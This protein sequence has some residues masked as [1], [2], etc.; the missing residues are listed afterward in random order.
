M[1]PLAKGL[2]TTSLI[3]GPLLTISSNHWIM[4]WCGLEIS[5]LSVIPLIAQQHHPRAI[6]A[7]IKYFLTQA[8]A[9]TM[10]LFSGVM[11][12]WHLGQWDMTLL[13]NNTLCMLLT[14]ALAMKLGLA[15]FHLWLPEV[16]QGSTMMTALLLTTW[17]KLAPL[18][19]LVITSHHLNAPLLLSLGLA[20]TLIGGWGGLNQTQLR[21]IMAFSSIAHLGWMTAILTMSPKLTLL[22]FYL[23]CVMTITTFLMIEHLKTNKMSTIMLSWTKTPSLNT[24]MLLTLMSLAGLPPLTGFSPKW[25]ILQELTKQHMTILATLMA[26]ASLL[27]LFFYLRVSY[28]T[29]ITLPPNSHNY[30]QQWRH[31]TSY[32]KPYLAAMAMLSTTLLPILPALLYS[33]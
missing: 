3:M 28:Y 16:L 1:N 29:T 19:I 25:L 20:S 15:P 21:K 8:A 6:E 7:A 23:Y 26:M 14:V 4:A 12:A 22:T 33:T 27:S 10:L 32:T 17:Q 11:N 30:T 18:T 5:T 13:H 31:K 9:S 2:I 24:L